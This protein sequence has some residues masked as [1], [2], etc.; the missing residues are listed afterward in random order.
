MIFRICKNFQELYVDLHNIFQF[1]LRLYDTVNFEKNC[2][3]AL[4]KFVS[5]SKTFRIAVKKIFCTYFFFLNLSDEN[6]S[7]LNAYFHIRSTKLVNHFKFINEYIVN[8]A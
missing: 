8:F 6:H 2:L 4:Y 5:F 1:L 3:T 7:F